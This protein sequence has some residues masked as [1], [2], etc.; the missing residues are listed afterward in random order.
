M[1]FVRQEDA[2]TVEEHLSFHQDTYQSGYAQPD[3]PR[4]QVSDRKYN[5]RYPSKDETPKM[6]DKTRRKVSRLCA[7]ILR[8]LRYPTRSRLGPVYHLYMQLPEPRMLHLEWHWKDRLLKIMGTPSKRNPEAMLRYFALIRDAKDAGLTIRRSHWNLALAFATKYAS[9]NT[10]DEVETALRLWKEME[11]GAGIKGNDVTFNVLFD[12]AIKVG[13]FPLGDMIY[14]EMEAR[15]VQ[16]NR[17][18]HVSVIHYFGL[19]LDSGGIRAAYRAMVEA[20]EMVDT[21]ALNCVISGLLR[22]GEEPAA[23]ETYQ[24]MKNGHAKAAEIPDRNYMTDKVVSRVLMLFAKVGKEH[25]ELQKTLQNN[26]DLTPNLRTYRLFI[27]HYSLRVGD[28][29][30]VAQYLDEMK[31]LKVPIHPTIFLGL[32]KGF[33]LHGGFAG[34]A[35]SEQ[36]LEG[37]L[38]ALYQAKDEGGQAFLIDRWVAIWALRAI[39][40]CS[41][42]D[43]VIRAYQ[44]LAARWDIHPEHYEFMESL[45]E[46]ILTG[47]DLKSSTGNWTGPAHRRFK[48]D[49]SPL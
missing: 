2:S 7:A 24:R 12:I 49:G 16:F 30:K 23:E 40:K 6:N 34:S 47:R 26:V 15:G 44:D 48:K 21:V 4:V 45:V 18:H 36:R 42:G 14:K 27:D 37:V 39:Q 31:Y 19:K 46:V 13:N 10:S 28:L 38:K 32:F 35:W 29:T 11:R 25:P 8:R 41:T 22:C 1:A 33:Y 5:G 9:H 20:G 3:G 17:Y 43:A